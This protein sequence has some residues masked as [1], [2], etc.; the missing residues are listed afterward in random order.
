M[1][2]PTIR[3]AFA[4]TLKLE[5]QRI[6]LRPPR[7]C[8]WR[9]WSAIRAESRQFLA[10]WEPSW[11][12]DALTRVAFRR[13]L[14]QQHVEWRQGVG[15]G[16]LVFRRADDALIGG[17]SLA[18]I[19]RGVAQTASLG[20]WIGEPFARKGFMTEALTAV[21]DFAFHQL[22]LHRVEAACLPN[23]AA[24]KALLGKV[25]FTEEG[26]ARHFLRINGKWQDHLLFAILCDDQRG[27]DSRPTDR[28]ATVGQC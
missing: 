12:Y 21:L 22:G 27:W 26:Y 8:D 3:P 7:Q 13:R 16:F 18:N 9:A 1:L 25:G 15:Y 28:A 19:R 20:Y 11:P 4:R 2:L 23:N 17:V 5:R 10:P 24:S 6:Y 14:R